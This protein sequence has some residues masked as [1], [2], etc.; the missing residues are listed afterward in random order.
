M[1]PRRASTTPM[2]KLP[3]RRETKLHTPL[4]EHWRNVTPSRQGLC[5]AA[6]TAKGCRI[7]PPD[8]SSALGEQ[9][10]RIEAVDP[11]AGILLAA[12][13]ILSGLPQGPQPTQAPPPVSGGSET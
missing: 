1:G 13:G 4:Q 10:K 12:D 5:H 9:L 8:A 2:H 6:A 11:K 3:H 7:R